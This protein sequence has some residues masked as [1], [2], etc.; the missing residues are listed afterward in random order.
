MTTVSAEKEL[1]DA[2]GW[3]GLIACWTVAGIG[4]CEILMRHPRL[5]A[6]LVL[7]ATPI[8]VGV[9]YGLDAAIEWASVRTFS[10]WKPMYASGVWRE[11]MVPRFVRKDKVFRPEGRVL[12]SP[13]FPA[14]FFM[15]FSV[16]PRCNLEA[17]HWMEAPHP[18]WHCDV[19]RTCRDCGH[20]WDQNVGLVSSHEHG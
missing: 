18:H 19:V 11:V 4:I 16:C 3:A 20:V 5:G 10:R 2:A 6:L 17:L 14:D 15:P 9:A 7:V 12:I 13:L 8:F 1:H